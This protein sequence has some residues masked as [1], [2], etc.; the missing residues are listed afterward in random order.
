MLAEKGRVISPVCWTAITFT[1]D[2]GGRLVGNLNTFVC[3]LSLRA[4]LSEVK[5]KAFSISCLG[6]PSTSILLYMNRPEVLAEL[7]SLVVRGNFYCSFWNLFQGE[8]SCL[9]S[10]DRSVQLK[11]TSK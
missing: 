9:H 6:L 2:M 1:S 3:L 11:A 5:Q 8:C 7:N 10:M 4:E